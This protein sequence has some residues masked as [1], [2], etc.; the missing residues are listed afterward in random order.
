MSI[1]T[2]AMQRSRAITNRLKAVCC[3]RDPLRTACSLHRNFLYG[4]HSVSV[5]YTP[6]M[7]INIPVIR[8]QMEREF[9]KYWVVQGI[10]FGLAKARLKLSQRR[11]LSLL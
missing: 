3:L 5:W 8:W 6:N 2:W 1:F 10:L 11:S 7:V 4:Q 9:N